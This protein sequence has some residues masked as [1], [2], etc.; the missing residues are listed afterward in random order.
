VV[1][2]AEVMVVPRDAVD[3]VVEKEEEDG[4]TTTG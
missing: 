2:V 1:V 4:T 3:V